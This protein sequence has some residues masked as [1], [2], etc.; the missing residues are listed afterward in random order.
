MIKFVGTALKA[1]YGGVS[2]SL[3]ALGS[4]LIGDTP[5]SA[6]TAGQWVWV[7]SAGLLAFGAIYGV[8]NSTPKKP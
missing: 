1:I 2:A 5:I 4:I 7:A 6:V 3:A 8:T